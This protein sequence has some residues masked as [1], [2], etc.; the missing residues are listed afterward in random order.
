MLLKYQRLVLKKQK[1]IQV[2]ATRKIEKIAI[3]VIRSSSTIGRAHS[4]GN[5]SNN[6]A[7]SLYLFFRT[8][9]GI[10]SN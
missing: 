8:T 6:Q 2:E 9:P 1:E 3:E 5:L 4:V 10:L 7:T